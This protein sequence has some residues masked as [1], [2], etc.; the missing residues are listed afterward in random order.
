MSYTAAT[1]SPGPP[2]SAYG[3]LLHDMSAKALFTKQSDAAIVAVSV[4]APKYETNTIRNS[5]IDLAAL[6]ITSA[7]M[8][9]MV[10]L[11]VYVWRRRCREGACQTCRAR[12]RS[13]ASC[14][15]DDMEDHGLVWD[16]KDV[17]GKQD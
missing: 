8:A 2:G 16:P 4:L 7:L 10:V 13:N 6:A 3:N 14:R 11:G 12:H 1:R 5:V 15:E 17:A 9:G